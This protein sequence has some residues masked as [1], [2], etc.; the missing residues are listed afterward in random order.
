MNAYTLQGTSRHVVDEAQE[1]HEADARQSRIVLY[2]PLQEH[3]GKKK[4]EKGKRKKISMN[5][6]SSFKLLVR[7]A[8]PPLGQRDGADDRIHCAAKATTLR[9]KSRRSHRRVG[10]E[11][12]VLEDYGRDQ[13]AH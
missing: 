8:W 10:R 4:R 5:S 12:E 3:K 11:V 2:Q 1:G 13:E 7:M 9:R 6:M